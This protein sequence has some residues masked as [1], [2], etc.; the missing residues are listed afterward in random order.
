MILKRSGRDQD[1]FCLVNCYTHGVYQLKSCLQVLGA[2]RVQ[3][4]VVQV[5]DAVYVNC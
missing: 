2:C 3:E 4:P 5:G 1:I